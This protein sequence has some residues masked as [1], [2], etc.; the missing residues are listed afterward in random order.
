[1]TGGWIACA[2]KITER[3]DHQRGRRQ[4]TPIVGLMAARRSGVTGH[5]DAR[6]AQI[7][8]RRRTG[9]SSHRSIEQVDSR[10]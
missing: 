6:G 4:A 1:M 9:K 10:R 5:E 3:S 7:S 2:K 8:L